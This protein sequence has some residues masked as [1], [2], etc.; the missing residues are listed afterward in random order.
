MKQ[1]ACPVFRDER[2]EYAL[3]FTCEHC[4]YF[5][6]DGERCTHGYPNAAHRLARYGDAAEGELVFCKDFELL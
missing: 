3:R 2:V 4:S 1:R 6:V 5:A